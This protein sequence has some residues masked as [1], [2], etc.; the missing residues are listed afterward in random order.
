MIKISLLADGDPV[1]DFNCAYCI[2]G[3]EAA[4]A[5]VKCPGCGLV[6]HA[7]CWGL[8]GYACARPGC[9]TKQRLDWLRPF[10]QPK[11]SQ[12]VVPKARGVPE[13]IL[14]W[15]GFEHKVSEVR[16]RQVLSANLET[17]LLAFAMWT[18]VV[19]L[20]WWLDV[21]ALQNR[22]LHLKMDAIRAVWPWTALWV[23]LF[24]IASVNDYLR[25]KAGM[26][27]VGMAVRFVIILPIA[28][29]MAWLTTTLLLT[30][31]THLLPDA[32]R[33][34]LLVFAPY[35]LVFAVFFTL[36]SILFSVL[37]AANSV[38][39]FARLGVLWLTYIVAFVRCLLAALAAGGL[40]AAASVT[41]GAF[42]PARELAGTVFP[43]ASQTAFL[44]AMLVHLVPDAALV[45]DRLI[46]FRQAQRVQ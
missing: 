14:R 3:F 24:I 19:L 38:P 7:Q 37:V 17:W 4:E 30:V 16:L 34:W 13:R 11:V 28:L 43:L 1:P 22:A 9:D 45:R 23:T 10:W 44:V 18:L 26:E 20:T 31:A 12:P 41:I 25:A 6:Q 42:V 46:E 5:V 33:W 35:P 8:N 15:F 2:L 32:Q 27:G 39:L 40:A 29:A 21:P 36:P